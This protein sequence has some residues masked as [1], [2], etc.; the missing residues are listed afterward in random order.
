MGGLF[1]YADVSLS[2]VERALD[3]ARAAGVEGSDTGGDL[4]VDADLVGAVLGEAK[5]EVVATA[6][7]GHL[8]FGAHGSLVRLM[9][10]GASAGCGGLL[11]VL[12]VVGMTSVSISVVGT[13]VSLASGRVSSSLVSNL[14]VHDHEANVGI[15]LERH[16][17]GAFGGEMEAANMC[18]GVVV[19]MEGDV[20]TDVEQ[21][22]LFSKNG[23]SAELVCSHPLACGEGGDDV[24][25]TDP[26]GAEAELQA[27]KW[28]KS[29][30]LSRSQ[31][32]EGE[33]AQSQ[34]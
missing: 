2:L 6:R 10:R 28:I 20:V 18:A 9:S 12:G 31:S 23:L 19:V 3:G 13:V 5:D 11:R 33:E 16:I 29:D 14:G 17:E 8:E 25:P 32:H 1:A 24:D 26:R 27:L 22:W 4:D 30:G 21:L 7:G 15:G 34:E